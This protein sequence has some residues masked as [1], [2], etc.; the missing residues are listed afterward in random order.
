[1]KAQLWCHHYLASTMVSAPCLPCRFRSFVGRWLLNKVVNHITR[2]SNSSVLVA[3][4]VDTRYSCCFVQANTRLV[5]S[6][7][8]KQSMRIQHIGHNMASKNSADGMERRLRNSR[9]GG[10]KPAG[11]SKVRQSDMKALTLVCSN[12]S[13]SCLLAAYDGW[14]RI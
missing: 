2:Y 11:A 13:I 10:E 6:H 8:L 5:T 9:P 3:A 1:V 7:L 12:C 14:Y 4:R